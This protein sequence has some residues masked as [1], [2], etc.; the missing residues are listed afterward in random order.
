MLILKMASIWMLVAKSTIALCM[1]ILRTDA[2]SP[3]LHNDLIQRF[4]VSSISLFDAR[5]SDIQ[6]KLKAQMEKLQERDR[7]S[8]AVSSDVSSLCHLYSY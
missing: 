3:S 1:L 5:S 2:F 8:C 7:R 6:E 4:P